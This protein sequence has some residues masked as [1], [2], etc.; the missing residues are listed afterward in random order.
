MGEYTDTNTKLARDAVVTAPTVTLYATLGLLDFI[1]SSN[2]T[3]LFRAG[4]AQRV[5]SILATRL[6]N[7]GRRPSTQA[8]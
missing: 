4:Q 8:A 1:R 2:G 6:A 3:R 5:R 7:R